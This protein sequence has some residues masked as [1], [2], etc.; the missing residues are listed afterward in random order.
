MIDAVDFQKAVNERNYQ[1]SSRL[2]GKV[3]KD[4]TLNELISELVTIEE[5]ATLI[6]LEMRDHV[7]HYLAMWDVYFGVQISS[8]DVLRILLEENIRDDPQTFMVSYVRDLLRKNDGRFDPF[9][10]NIQTISGG[11]YAI[12][13]QPIIEQRTDELLKCTIPFREGSPRLYC[14]A[15][16]L[17]TYYGKKIVSAT[18]GRRSFDIVINEDEY[19]TISESLESTGFDITPMLVKLELDDWETYVNRRRR[20]RDIHTGSDVARPVG[21]SFGEISVLHRVK[22]GRSVIYASV[23]QQQDSALRAIQRAKTQLC[24]DVLMDVASDSSHPMRKRAIHE[25]GIM[26]DSEALLF[27]NHL[28]KKDGNSSIQREAA[29]AY[30]TLSSRSAGMELGPPSSEGKPPALDITE[31]N[32]T[33]NSLLEKALP[34]TM[35]DEAMSSVAHQGGENVVDVLLRFFSKPQVS[36]R[37]A[38][39]KASRI[40]D[41]PDA[42]LIIKTALDDESIE[43]V[44]F[45]E[46]EIDTRWSD[47]VWK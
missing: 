44:R 1:E 2:L 14:V 34:T 6:T 24:N 32:Q 10:I 13:V 43:V 3:L 20:P 30:S 35:I 36:V 39:L 12:L 18:L 47:D 38:I 41:K 46:N 37:L 5:G 21:K 45:A 33:L 17:D 8:I 22:S 26:G 23:F 9:C 4:G 11:H 31:I 7:F 40:L 19:H 27:L 15:D 25:L 28:M 29:R 42:A 16:L